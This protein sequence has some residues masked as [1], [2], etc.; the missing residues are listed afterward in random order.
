MPDVHLHPLIR[1]E[2]HSAEELNGLA[3]AFV[4]PRTQAGRVVRQ[5]DGRVSP[6]P[7]KE[8]SAFVGGGFGGVL[9]GGPLVQAE[10]N[11]IVKFLVPGQLVGRGEA[12]ELTATGQECDA[13]QQNQMD[14]FD[15]PN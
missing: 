1:D 13:E 14:L 3:R 9:A 2:V 5:E 4:Q 11:K 15:R 12:L 7:V 6:E 10:Q 8:V